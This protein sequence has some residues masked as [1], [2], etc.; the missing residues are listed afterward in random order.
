MELHLVDIMGVLKGRGAWEKQTK[1]AKARRVLWSGVVDILV[2]ATK[3]NREAGADCGTFF[4]VRGT[5]TATCVAFR[6]IEKRSAD[7]LYVRDR[8]LRTII[9]GTHCRGS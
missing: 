6:H 2:G 4:L 9:G 5:G 7:G 3:E 8:G 1:K